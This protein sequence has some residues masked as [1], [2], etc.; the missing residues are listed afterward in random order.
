MKLI[1]LVVFSGT[2]LFGANFYK[3]DNHIVDS[4]NNT[5][6]QDT[7]D[8]IKILRNQD[9]AMVYCENLELDGYSDWRLPSQKEFAKIIDKMRKHNEPKIVKAFEY[10]ALEHYWIKDKTWRNFNKWGYYAYLTSGT[11]YYDNKT[12][13]KYVKCLR[14]GN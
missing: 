4:V 1:L 12:Y 6:W 2:I 5:M 9:E 3:V 7:K 8:D 11:F 14:G 13:L 10:A